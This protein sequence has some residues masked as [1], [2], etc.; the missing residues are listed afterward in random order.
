M[1]ITQA[2]FR[3]SFFGGGTDF[4]AFYEKYGGKVISTSIDK[5]CYVNKSLFV[6]I[7]SFDGM[8]GHQHCHRK[9]TAR[10][11][12]GPGRKIRIVG[13][14]QLPHI[15]ELHCLPDCR[16]LDPADTLAPWG[17]LSTL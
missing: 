3:M 16:M 14:G 1:V 5:Y 7:F 4:P 6:Y 12:A 11:Q 8:E 10:P 15:Q 9:R 2:P 17:I 13:K